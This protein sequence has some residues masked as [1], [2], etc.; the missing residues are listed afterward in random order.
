M[1]LDSTIPSKDNYCLTLAALFEGEFCI[2]WLIEISGHKPSHLLALL[3]DAVQQGW[4]L[5]KSHGYF[6]FENL[7]IKK[8]LK[9]TLNLTELQF[10]HQ[11][12][13]FFLLRESSI[14]EKANKAII[15]HLPFIHNDLNGCLRL[16]DAADNA[17]N[18][19]SYRMAAFYYKKILNDLREN[20]E[21]EALLLFV[22]T[23][24]KY[25]RI[26]F[27]RENTDNV[28]SLLHEAIVK[29]KRLNMKK[30]ASLL[31]MHLAINCF[32][33]GGY[34]AAT[35]HVKEG[36][37]ILKENASF[38]KLLE[39]AS[40][41]QL[42]AYIWQ[43]LIKKVIKDYETHIPSIEI[44]PSERHRILVGSVVGFC[45]TQAGQF[46][47][48]L[49]MLNALR[50]HCLEKNDPILA[51][52]IEV[53]TAGAMLELQLTDEC[54]SYLEKYKTS[55]CDDSDWNVIRA[56]LTL[57]AAYFFQRKQK[58]A[59]YYFN[60]W[61][62]LSISTNVNMMLIPFAWLEICLAMEEGTFPRLGNIHIEDE[63]RK[64]LE[65]ENVLLKG[66]AYRYM[67]IM[68]RRKNASPEK[69]IESL[70]LSIRYLEDAGHLL[71]LCRT[72]VILMRQ[73]TASGNNKGAS[74]MKSKILALLMECN[75]D[76]IPDEFN[77]FIKPHQDLQILW[78][79]ILK[80]SQD[81]SSIRNQ[82]QL[83]QTILSTANRISGAERGAI[84]KVERIKENDKN[85]DSLRSKLIA[86]KNI[87]SSQIIDQDFKVMNKLMKEVVRTGKG[88]IVRHNKKEDHNKI[89]LENILSQICVPMVCRNKIVG[90]LY[91][92]NNLFINPFQESDLSLLSYFAAQAAIAMDHAEAYEQIQSYNHKLN[93]EK[94]YYKEQSCSSIQLDSFVGKSP[95]ILEVFN[96][97]NQ[98]ANTETNVIILGE[99]GVGKGLV[100]EAIH[101]HS[102]RNTQPFV[103]VLCNALPENLIT[104][105]LFGHEKGAFTGSIQRQIG[106]FELADGGT[107]FLDEIGELKEDVQT[108]LLQVIQSKEFQRVGNSETIRSDFR[109]VT[110]TNR[111]LS[112]AV[113]NKKFRA[114]LY[115]RLH[116]FPIYVPPLRERK[117][118]IP[119][120][121]IHFL[122][123]F[124][125]K[126]GKS[127]IGIPKREMEKLLQY[128]WPGNI[129]EL[130]GII[131]RGVILS[132]SDYFRVP[133]LL[134]SRELK[135]MT[136]IS[137]LEDNERSCI[138]QA[139]KK[140]NWK[141]RGEGGA[142]NLLN[143]NYSTLFF[144]M[145][146]LGI[147]RPPEI[148]KGRQKMSLSKIG[149]EVVQS[150]IA[151]TRE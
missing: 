114:D 69:I 30:E 40:A 105:E 103:K 149:S 47:Q 56:K 58:E 104:S 31:L 9:E 125:K 19:C 97:V 1:K 63:I 120:L 122:N 110:A 134:E 5:R 65:E 49:G 70:N 68:Q 20:L 144:R 130:E 115:Y 76:F 46:T 78:D 107:I 109:L 136:P 10:W 18:V 29:A 142:A 116:V 148:P 35:Q 17:R 32:L 26:S 143:I 129:R 81:M 61:L 113:K 22:E 128:E 118:D 57:A 21:K 43:G 112:D 67:A 133:E 91:L 50:K 108:R 96:K 15:H 101:M 141:V 38:T 14:D 6:T 53:T 71:E 83:L 150:I 33:Q 34:R 27:A 13:V 54:L 89:D 90:V 119:L 117:E 151:D 39:S 74:E 92:E 86:S 145:K 36:I 93:Q 84:F 44:F 16:L 11:K 52:D 139:L 80:L 87:T 62:K 131:E 42:Y 45:Y 2:D 37:I 140:T 8:Q 121:A 95:S 146:K 66:V 111:N 7:E 23:A 98:V 94:Q 85:K 73:Y 106:R 88:K 79:E 64:F 28:S 127:F 59:I 24:I 123:I 3:D 99:T 72:Y 51:S 12:I 48:G 55:D 135:S 147:E 77:S 4:L 137:T 100:A 138:L 82:K 102:K 60:Q 25:A 75:R 124:S 126:T 41:F 132:R